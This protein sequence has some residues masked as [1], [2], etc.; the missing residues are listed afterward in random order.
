MKGDNNQLKTFV[1][2]QEVVE[3]AI[4]AYFR[5]PTYPIDQDL[6]LDDN[7]SADLTPET[8][9]FSY[10]KGFSIISVKNN[11]PTN[12]TRMVVSVSGRDTFYGRLFNIYESEM[13]VGTIYWIRITDIKGIKIE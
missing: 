5:N 11:H 3:S 1:E 7:S 4:D 2:A 13:S 10:K 12:S 9:T 8:C 6:Y